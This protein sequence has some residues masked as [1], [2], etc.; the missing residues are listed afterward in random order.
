MMWIP[1]RSPK[2]YSFIFG[3]HRRASW[4]KLTPSSSNSFIV[5]STANFPPLGID[6]YPPW[7]LRIAK[8]S[9]AEHP[10]CRLLAGREFVPS[11]LAG[12]GRTRYLALA[13]LE[14]L[15][16]ALLPV[17]LAFL[18]ARIARQKPVLAQPCAEFRIEEGERAGKPHAQRAGLAAYAPAVHRG[19]DVDRIR[20]LGELH[21]FHGAVAP[22]DVE[23]VLVRGSAVDGNLPGTKCQKYS[24]HR[25]FAAPRAVK[26]LFRAFFRLCAGTQLSSSHPILKN[27]NIQQALRSG[28]PV[29]RKSKARA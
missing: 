11:R 23:E 16:G 13:E 29:R 8:L 28:Q 4:S 19:H 2:I 21:R 18:H 20:R 22:V 7:T 10:K 12:R 24:R 3:F 17:F 25:F 14:A 6:V 9:G 1:L 26:F 5:I 15:A 27:F